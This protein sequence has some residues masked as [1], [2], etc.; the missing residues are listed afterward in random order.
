MD[1][2]NGLKPDE[3]SS[4]DGDDALKLAGTQGHHFDV[5]YFKRPRWKMSSL[6]PPVYLATLP[7]DGVA[8]VEAIW[9]EK[10]FRVNC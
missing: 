1:P 2:E 7:T 3:A 5:H 9:R 6:P 8:G 10:L 4:T